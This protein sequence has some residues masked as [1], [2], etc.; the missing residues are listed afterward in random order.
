MRKLWMI[1]I[2]GVS[3]WCWGVAPAEAGPKPTLKRVNYM[4]KHVYWRV[5]WSGICLLEMFYNNEAKA[6]PWMASVA[7][8]E[9]AND[10]YATNWKL[11]LRAVRWLRSQKHAEA[12]TALLKVAL[13]EKN[14]KIRTFLASSLGHAPVWKKK[15]LVI[16]QS[17]SKDKEKAVQ[18]VAKRSLLQL[19]TDGLS[20][21][22]IKVSKSY[23][24]PILPMN[25]EGHSSSS[26]L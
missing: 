19:S 7:L 9:N 1:G 24:K 5:K 23:N 20:K 2:L 8:P 6:I 14:I 17:L 22:K 25:N 13:H 26:S 18:L 12:W 3:L 15:A 4:L 16:L 11:R 10:A 21:K